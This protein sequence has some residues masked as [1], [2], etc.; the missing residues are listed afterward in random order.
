MAPAHP[1]Q[2]EARKGLTAPYDSWKNRIA[3]LAFVRDIPLTD[4]DPAYA[5]VDKVDRTLA[6][7]RPEKLLILWGM[8]D[9]V[10]DKA[11]LDEWK[12][13]FPGAACQV[14][15]DAGHYL[16][17]DKPAETSAAVR[18]FFRS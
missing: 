1:L 11:F 18:A 9:F 14:F 10:F 7:I 4:G 13:R 6:A 12:K 16:F 15:P 8:K 3:T 2:R 5:A 17:E